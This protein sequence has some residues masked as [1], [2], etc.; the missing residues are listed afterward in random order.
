MGVLLSSSF[1][2]NPSADDGRSSVEFVQ[3]LNSPWSLECAKITI[4][5]LLPENVPKDGN[6]SSSS[7]S[8]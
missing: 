7:D 1:F 5:V 3:T 2:H 6:K 4:Q 8:K